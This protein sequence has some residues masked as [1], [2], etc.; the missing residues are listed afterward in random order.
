MPAEIQSVSIPLPM[1]ERGSTYLFE[2]RQTIGRNGAGAAVT[3]P[4]ARLTWKWQ[5]MSAADFAF[6]YTTAAAGAAS[7]VITQAKLYNHLQTLQTFTAGI[8]YAPTYETMKNGEYINVTVTIES[9]A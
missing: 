5:T 6:W 7:R 4:Y 2:P 3:L 1:A 9:L 8:V